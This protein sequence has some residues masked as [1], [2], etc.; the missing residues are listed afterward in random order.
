MSTSKPQPREFTGKHMLL[1]MLAF[2]GVIVA[3][4][5]TMAVFAS[6]SWTGL[7]VKNSYVASQAFN[8]ELE[9]AKAQAALGWSGDIIYTDGAIELSLLDKLG[10]PVFLDQ[11]VVQ[12][13][14]PAFEQSD[15]K[16]AMVN[17]GNG[18]YRAEDALEPGVWQVSI[19]GASNQGAYR[20]D[21]RLVVKAA[22]P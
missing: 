20:L 14:R 13:G 6:T 4:N 22:K 3:V 21:T 12:V 16:L 17:Q 9:A 10:A 15:H 1:S 7:V 18:V 11:V 5:L 8:R 19:R 2:F